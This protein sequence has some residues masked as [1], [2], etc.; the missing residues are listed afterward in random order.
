MR[1]TALSNVYGSHMVMRL[2]ME[3]RILSGIQRLPVLQSEFA[4][5]ESMTGA[6]TEIDFD[7]YL[8]VPHNRETSMPSV[9]VLME[10]KMGLMTHS[11]SELGK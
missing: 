6:D 11:P 7:D 9:H 10:Q 3:K 8:N 1:N 4:G 5:L 2:E